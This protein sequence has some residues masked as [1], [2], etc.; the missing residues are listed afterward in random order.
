[1]IRENTVCTFFFKKC[2]I[3]IKFGSECIKS[4]TKDFRKN[5]A[6]SPILLETQ[7]TQAVLSGIRGL[8]SVVLLEKK[9]SSLAGTKK[10][11]SQRLTGPCWNIEIAPA[12]AVIW[13]WLR[14]IWFFSVMVKRNSLAVLATQELLWRLFRTLLCSFVIPSVLPVWGRQWILFFHKPPFMRL[15]I[16]IRSE[17]KAAPMPMVRKILEKNNLLPLE[18]IWAWLVSI[19]SLIR[20]RRPSLNLASASLTFAFLH[21]VL[22]QLSHAGKFTTGR[23]NLANRQEILKPIEIKLEKMVTANPYAMRIFPELIKSVLNCTNRNI[24]PV[25]IKFPVHI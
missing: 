14:R 23:L 9:N 24:A 19:A 22:N 1:M 16:K 20:L 7:R 11:L 10:E 2:Y 5:H 4:L 12:S 8:F 3:S 21:S 6:S 17:I 15:K 13:R 18:V 25:T